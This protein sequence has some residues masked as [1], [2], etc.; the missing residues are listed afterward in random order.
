MEGLHRHMSRMPWGTRGGPVTLWG[1][2]LARFGLPIAL[3]MPMQQ[4][5]KASSSEWIFRGIKQQSLCGLCHT[6]SRC[7]RV[8]VASHSMTVQQ[9]LGAPVTQE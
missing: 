2:R 5:R 7:L 3:C 9:S 1:T 4:V 6:Y 8:A